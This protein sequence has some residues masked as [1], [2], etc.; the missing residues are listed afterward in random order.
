VKID[1]GPVQIWSASLEYESSNLHKDGIMY[2]HITK[3]PAKEKKNLHCMLFF[4]SR[5]DQRT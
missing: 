2:V 4:P 3:N 5:A 1:G